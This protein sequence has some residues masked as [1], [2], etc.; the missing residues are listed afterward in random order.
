VNIQQIAPILTAIYIIGG[1]AFSLLTLLVPATL[2]ASIFLTKIES[3]TGR[4]YVFFLFVAT[5]TS[6]VMDIQHVSAGLD[7]PINSPPPET[8]ILLLTL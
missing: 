3:K 8:L 6:I 5:I 2:L 1:K 4:S 7:N